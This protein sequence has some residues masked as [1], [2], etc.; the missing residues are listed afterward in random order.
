MTEWIDVLT[1]QVAATSIWETIAVLLALGYV[2]LAA[3]QNIWCWLCALVSTGIYSYLFW[4]VSLPF[5]TL[6]NVY[7]LVMALY[8][9]SQWR[10]VQHEPDSIQRKSWQWHVGCIVA[11]ILIGQGVIWLV[12]DQLEQR[13]VVLDAY[14]SLFSVFTTILVAHKV[15]EN[16]LYWMV[17]NSFAAYLYFATGLLLTSLLFGLYVVFSV[18]GFIKWKANKGSLNAELI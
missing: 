15:L 14:I 1:E 18:Y 9:W 3:R 10:K 12:G 7:Y 5:H 16:W 13:F 17:I 11:M 2:W 8:G 4:E 6:L